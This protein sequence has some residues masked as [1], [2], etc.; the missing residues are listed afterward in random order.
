MASNCSR[1]KRCSESVNNRCVVKPKAAATL[2]KHK[3]KTARLVQTLRDAAPL[4][5]LLIGVVVDVEKHRL[6]GR[7]QRDVLRLERLLLDV[8]FMVLLEFVVA[9]WAKQ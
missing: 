2:A 6:N 8:A 4:L 9:W 5:R 3:Q 1:A 7:R